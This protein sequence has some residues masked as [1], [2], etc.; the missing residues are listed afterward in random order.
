MQA[1]L[2]KP[3]QQQPF[4]N[5]LAIVSPFLITKIAIVYRSDMD[6]KTHRQTGREMIWAG[7]G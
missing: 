6:R 4:E 5:N 7:S 1:D 3:Q 2:D